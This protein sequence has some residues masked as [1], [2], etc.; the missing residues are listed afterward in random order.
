M[1]HCLPLIFVCKLVIKNGY[2]NFVNLYSITK[3]NDAQVYQ[4][5]ITHLLHCA[6]TVM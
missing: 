1:N 4:Y 6:N 3:H 5:F 2:S